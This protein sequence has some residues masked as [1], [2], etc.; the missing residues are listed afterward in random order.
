ML[1]FAPIDQALTD[2]KQV[3]TFKGQDISES[4]AAI[5][6]RLNDTVMDWKNLDPTNFHTA[7]G[8]DALKQKIGDVRDSLPYGSMKA[9]AIR[10][11]TNGTLH[12]TECSA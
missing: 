5:R 11:T 1:D 6:Q 4:T 12:V 8:F 2:I 10:V 9:S 3:K 7:E